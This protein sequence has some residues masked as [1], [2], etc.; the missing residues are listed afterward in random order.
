[1][2]ALWLCLRLCQF[3][4]SWDTLAFNIEKCAKNFKK[5]P[6][7]TFW[8]FF[9]EL[10]N[11]L[12]ITKKTPETSRVLFA[13]L[14]QNQE[15]PGLLRSTDYIDWIGIGNCDQET[16]STYPYI[17]LSCT[18]YVKYLLNYLVNENSFYSVPQLHHHI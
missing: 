15:D 3:K 14:R 8:F 16:S 9:T 11:V 2:S 5:K 18:Q 10:K 4:I 7:K 13:E 6:P 1:M 12:K 17:I